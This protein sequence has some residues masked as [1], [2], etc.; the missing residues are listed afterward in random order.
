MGKR[1]LY[2]QAN[3]TTCKHWRAIYGLEIT[4]LPI[5]PNLGKVVVKEQPSW[6]LKRHRAAGCVKEQ[7]HVMSNFR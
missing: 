2:Y 5:F 1:K 3:Q 4:T 6:P 7:E